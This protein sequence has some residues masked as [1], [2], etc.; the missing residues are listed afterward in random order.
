MLLERKK[1]FDLRALNERLESKNVYKNFFLFIMGLVLSSISVSVFYQPNNITVAGST[2]VAILINN[3]VDVDLSLIILSIS[4]IM[5]VLGFCVFGIEYGA[6]NILGTILFP[7]FVKAASLL[8]SVIYFENTSMFVLI[9]FGAFLSGSGF[10]LVTKSGYSQ[11]GFNVLYDILNKKF[12]ISVGKA[13]MF[14]NFFIILISSFVVGINKCVYAFIDL[15][16]SN[17]IADKIMMGIS[18]NKA[19]Y[20]IT[21]KPL[22][23]RDYIVNNSK[24]SVTIVN[25]KGGYT[26]KKKKLLLCAIPTIEYTR[27]KEVIREIDKDVFFLITDCYFVSK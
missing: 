7:I 8:K 20:I 6:K 9:L 16:I 4:S 5:L 13:S 27:F 17:N 12:K 19:F 22:D 25:A 14:F 18:N 23:I 2:G 26:N 11:G 24:Y 3:F 10:G 21:K 15:Y 1:K